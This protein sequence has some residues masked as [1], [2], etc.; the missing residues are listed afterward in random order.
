MDKTEN[1]PAANSIGPS[2]NESTLVESIV[3]SGYPLQGVVASKLT[4]SFNVVDEWGFMDGDQSRSLDI[5][6]HRKLNGFARLKPSVTLL[7]EC[8][9][10]FQPVIFFKNVVDRKITSFPTING[11]GPYLK[12]LDAFVSIDRRMIALRITSDIA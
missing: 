6:A 8:K 1:N 7:V 10:S 11:V 4:K 3:T 12:T 5:F 9:R 2:V